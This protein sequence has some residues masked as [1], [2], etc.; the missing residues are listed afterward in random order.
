MDPD[1]VGRFWID[2]K[3]RGQPGPP[4]AVA[5]LGVLQEEV[6][7]ISG[8]IGYMRDG[9]VDGQLKVLAIDGKRPTPPTTLW[10]IRAACARVPR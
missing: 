9:E 6:A 1:Q 5:P 2:R 8:T 10:S 4:R 7:S 3:I